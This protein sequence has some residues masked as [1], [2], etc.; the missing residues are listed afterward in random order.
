MDKATSISLRFTYFSSTI[1]IYS[2]TLAALGTDVI[3]SL[4][5]STPPTLANSLFFSN[6]FVTIVISI[7]VPWSFKL[8]IVLNIFV[9]FSR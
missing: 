4:K 3:I 5:Y 2:S 6:S 8:A 1:L 9:C 7:G